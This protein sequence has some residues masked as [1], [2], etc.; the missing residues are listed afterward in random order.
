MVQIFLNNFLYQRIQTGT[1]E[2]DSHSS[3]TEDF[4]S[5]LWTTHF[6]TKLREVFILKGKSYTYPSGELVQLIRLWSL[7][8]QGNA[9]VQQPLAA[10]WIFCSWQFR[11]GISSLLTTANTHSVSA[12]QK[13]LD[14]FLVADHWLLG[15]LFKG[16]AKG[17]SCGNMRV[18]I[19]WSIARE[20]TLVLMDIQGKQLAAWLVFS[21]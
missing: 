3:P 10:S 20:D 8:Q 2:L 1:C 5:W 14:L 4:R 6:K 19:V 11:E 21:N 12:F 9:H 17:E 15:L 7:W 13:L 16:K 18:S